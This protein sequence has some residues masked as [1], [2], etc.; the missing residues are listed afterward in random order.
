VLV[1]VEDSEALERKMRLFLPKHAKKKFNN[2]E[3]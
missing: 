3:N 2:E 1:C